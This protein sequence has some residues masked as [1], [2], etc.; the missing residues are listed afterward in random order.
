[1]LSAGVQGGG[2]GRVGFCCCVPAESLEQ[3]LQ[4]VLGSTSAFLVK[5]WTSWSCLFRDSIA[6]LTVER[7]TLPLGSNA[8]S[9]ALGHK[10]G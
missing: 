5:H 7:E 8:V 6:H 9:K 10:L 2:H 3:V 4:L 1:M